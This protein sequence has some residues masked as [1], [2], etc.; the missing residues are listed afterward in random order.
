M[1]LRRMGKRMYR[2]YFLCLLT[3]IK[4]PPC[5][6]TNLLGAYCTPSADACEVNSVPSC[7]SHFVMCT[8][9]CP[10]KNGDFRS[11]FCFKISW[12]WWLVIVFL[13]GKQVRFSLGFNSH[14][15]G[16]RLS[17]IPHSEHTIDFISLRPHSSLR[18][19]FTTF[20]EC[21]RVKW[22]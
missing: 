22:T 3:L 13:E 18:L 9:L 1:P 17:G 12:N 7:T 19:L 4:F 6:F 16:A 8:N 15:L 11:Q 5:K 20:C 14:F 2:V 21:S 10:A